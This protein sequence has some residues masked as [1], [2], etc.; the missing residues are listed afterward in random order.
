MGVAIGG[1]LFC[2]VVYLN[3]FWPNSPSVIAENQ[4]FELFLLVPFSSAFIGSLLGIII[5]KV[6]NKR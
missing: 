4:Y 5:F 3:V 6:L 2:L 1:L